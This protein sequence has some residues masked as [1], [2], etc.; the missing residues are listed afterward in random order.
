LPTSP[1]FLKMCVVYS[2]V[3]FNFSHIFRIVTYAEMGA[4]L[5]YVTVAP[6]LYAALA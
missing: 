3:L 1:I 6:V 4:M 2:F 5:S